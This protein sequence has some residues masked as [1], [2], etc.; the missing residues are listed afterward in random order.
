MDAGVLTTIMQYGV[1]NMNN[2]KAL[3]PKNMQP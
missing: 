3:D 1:G 2:I